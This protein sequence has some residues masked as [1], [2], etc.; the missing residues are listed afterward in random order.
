M[1]VLGAFFGCLTVSA[2]GNKFGRRPI[3]NIAS[4]GTLLG[5]ALQAGSVNLGMFVAS[6]LINGFFVGILTCIVPCLMAELSKP[7]IR[8]LMMSLEL[9]FAASG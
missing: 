1:F 5:A 8:G 2:I 6:R 3:L 4:F 9:V 7:K